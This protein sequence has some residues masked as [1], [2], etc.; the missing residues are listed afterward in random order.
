[1]ARNANQEKL[2]SRVGDRQ[3][4]KPQQPQIQQRATSKFG[5]GE[6]TTDGNGNFI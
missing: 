2:G 1:M 6:I 3:K 4:S 5:T